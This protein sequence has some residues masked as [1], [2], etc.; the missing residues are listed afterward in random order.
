MGRITD[1]RLFNLIHDYFMLYRPNYKSA[2]EHTLH[3]YRKAMDELLD[4]V[5]Q[6]YSITFFEVS[7]SRKRNAGIPPA[8]SGSLA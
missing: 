5:K 2:S 7:F 1:K 4:F 8:T 3:S 6:K